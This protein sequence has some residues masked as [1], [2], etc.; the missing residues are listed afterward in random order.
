MINHIDK[1]KRIFGTKC[2]AININGESHN[3]INIP[4]GNTRLC[5]AVKQSIKV[6]VRIS[7]ENLDCPGARRSVAFEN[8][9]RQLIKEIAGHSQISE[10][11]IINALLT[12]PALNG[13]RHI[14]L[15]VT[16]SM[17]NDLPPDLYIMYVQPFKITNLMH[18]LA[19]M[20]ISPSIPS[21]SFLSVCGNVLANCYL[22]QAVS[23]SFG[24]PESRTHGGIGKNE[25][26]FGLPAKAASELLQYF[27]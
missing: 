9:E 10:N 7:K 1:L 26:V 15:G 13:I 21:Y 6:P 22:N 5:E 24:C 20:E 19:K 8:D 25:V 17:E 16:E 23:I 4:S 14:N 11:Y 2:T 3:F 12:I 18:N 27:M